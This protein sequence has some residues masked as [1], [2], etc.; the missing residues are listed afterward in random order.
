MK[1]TTNS[2]FTGIRRNVETTK[3]S[4]NAANI[5]R[6]QRKA[7][8]KLYEDNNGNDNFVVVK[9]ININDSGRIE[10]VFY[11][12]VGNSPTVMSFG[13]LYDGPDMQVSVRKEKDE[14]SGELTAVSHTHLTLP[15]NVNV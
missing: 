12:T 14:N 13:K 1:N 2:K 3:S 7:M 8:H 4:V 9:R 5:E 15:T 6:L 11:Q 10:E